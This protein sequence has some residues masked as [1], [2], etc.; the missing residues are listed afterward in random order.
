MKS[1]PHNGEI[2]FNGIQRLISQGEYNGLSTLIR[3]EGAFVQYNA[4]GSY[5]RRVGLGI[6]H[7]EFLIATQVRLGLF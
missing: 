2:L 3:A 4:D 5:Y 6:T 1:D 7:Q